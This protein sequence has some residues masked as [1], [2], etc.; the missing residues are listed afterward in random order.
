MRCILRRETDPYFNLAAEEYVFKNFEEDTFMLWRNEPSVIIGKHQN[1]FAEVNALFIKQNN[2][3]V[4]RRIS[5]GGAVYHDTGNLNFTFTSKAEPEHLVDFKRYTAPIVKA[6]EKLGIEVTEGARNSLYINGLKFSGNAEHVY[7]EKVIHHGTILFNCNLEALHES[8][9]PPVTEY[10]D[11]AVK[12]IRSKVTN[13]SGFLKPPVAGMFDRGSNDLKDSGDNDIDIKDFAGYILHEVLDSFGNAYV[14]EF[15]DQDIASINGLAGSKY[16]GWE[17]NYGYSPPFSF[18]ATIRIS[19]HPFQ[20][21]FF[22]VNGIIT[23]IKPKGKLK[24]RKDADEVIRLLT[25]QPFNDEILIKYL[26]NKLPEDRVTSLIESLFYGFNA[27]HL[28]T[29]GV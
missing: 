4:V 16:S 11:K 21:T 13:I 25:S 29:A 2:I 28:H 6:L 17:W 27:E 8:I 7:K 15:T 10:K 3:K 24:S 26:E 20:A 5:G 14:Y 1:A 19:V 9:K 23:E 12:S 22:I 18:D